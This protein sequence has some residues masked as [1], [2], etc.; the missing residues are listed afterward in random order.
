ML[1]RVT[2]LT[3]TVLAL[4]APTFA[5]QCLHGTTETPDQAARRKE[6]LT[7]TRNVNNL[8]ANQPGARNG[9]YLRHAELASSPF[10]ATSSSV[11][12]LNLTPD[13]ELLPGWQLTL[14]L[15]AHG[16]WFMVK[17]KTDACGFAYIS[18]QNGLIFNSEPIRPGEEP[19][20][21]VNRD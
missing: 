4:A 3:I 9:V 19:A 18:N 20:V 21:M 6:A 1:K 12:K 5:Q 7:A 8:E 16:Y 11:K 15:S 17:D 2:C 13:A 10:A 14:D